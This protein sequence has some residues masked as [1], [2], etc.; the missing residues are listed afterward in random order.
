[1]D[2]SMV[3]K[4]TTVLIVNDCVIKRD[5]TPHHLKQ[6]PVILTFPHLIEVIKE[7][8]QSLSEWIDFSIYDM[9]HIRLSAKNGNLMYCL[10]NVRTY[11]KM[12]KNNKK[13]VKSETRFV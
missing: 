3:E 8:K 4:A 7:R 12:C 2:S 5:E 11:C 9:H 10:S 13:P 1:M 6:L